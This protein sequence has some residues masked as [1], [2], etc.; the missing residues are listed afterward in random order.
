ML[1]LL[2]PASRKSGF[3][4][5]L[6]RRDFLTIGGT[7][8]ASGLSLPRL[9]A[10]ESHSGIRHTHKAV[11][12]VFLPGGPPHL[13]MW[14]IKTEA[15]REIRGEFNPIKTNVPGIEICEHF[16]RIAAMMDKFVAIR[17]IAG[18]S[19]DHDAYQCMTGRKK[20][21]QRP[22]YWPALGALGFQGARP[23][24]PG[25]P[26]APDPDVPHRRTPLGL[27]RRGRLPRHGPRPFPPGRR[28]GAEHEVGQH[29]PQGHD[30]GP[31]PGPRRPASSPSIP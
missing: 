10:A 22:D 6:S 27:S 26:A 13:D 11:I 29:G 20:E 31:P 4:D 8:M 28:A 17:S 15:P 30:A 5:R 24:Q 25:H 18:C 23:G 21:P 7:L 14:D 9:L 16:P 3:C 1:T 19:G 12:N 2:G